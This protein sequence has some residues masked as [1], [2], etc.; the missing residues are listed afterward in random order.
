MD[1][2]GP[3]E[4]SQGRS[5]Q[6]RWVVLFTCLVTRAVHLELANDLTAASCLMA[7]RRF[8]GRRGMPLEFWSDNGTNL[9]AA[10]KEIM[11]KIRII[12]EECADTFTDARTRWRFIPPATPHMGGSWERLVRTV[13]EALETILDGKRLTDEIFHTA[14]VEAEDMVNSRPLIYVPEG[15]SNA[16]SPNHFLRGISPN[17]PLQVP[18]PPHSAEALRNAYYRSQE[19]SEQLWQRW[20][21]EYVPMINKRSKWFAETKPLKTGDL[22]YVTDGKN[23]ELWV[24]GT[25][26]ELIVSKDCRIRQAWLQVGLA[27][28]L[29]PPLMVSEAYIDKVDREQSP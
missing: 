25:V 11:E 14:I 24:R 6:K 12:E 13:K 10:G 18:P 3:V 8:V 19:L 7:I 9:K 15:I 2:F 17:E 26:V 23:R 28:T 16:I 27:C 1:Y 4:V 20:I 21:K 5:K 22:V 29:Q